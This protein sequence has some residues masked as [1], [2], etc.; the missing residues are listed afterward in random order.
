VDVEESIDA[1]ER[2]SI[3]PRTSTLA[4]ALAARRHR[5]LM[6]RWSADAPAGRLLVV[7]QVRAAPEGQ[8][9]VDAA[10]DGCNE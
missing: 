2:W 5:G 8:E 4:A 9:A 3:S 10:L 7:R 1:L 6:A